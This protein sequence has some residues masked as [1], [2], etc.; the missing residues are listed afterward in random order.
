VIAAVSKISFEITLDNAKGLGKGKT[1]VSNIGKG[2]AD[3]IHEFLDTGT[4]G[5][6]EEKRE[7]HKA[8]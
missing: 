6:L 5:K 7:I 1:K 2:S 3:K 4:I 8:S